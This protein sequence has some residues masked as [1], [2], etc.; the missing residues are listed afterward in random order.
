M[1]EKLGGP[2][3]LLKRLLIGAGD[4]AQGGRKLVTDSYGVYDDTLADAKRLQRIFKRTEGLTPEQLGATKQDLFRGLNE[5]NFDNV[6]S[7][8]D[9]LRSK[10]PTS[11][12]EQLSNR[13]NVQ[14]TPQQAEAIRKEWGSA[15]SWGEHLTPLLLGD[16]PINVWQERIER[17]GLLGKGGLLMSELMPSRTVREGVKSV[18]SNISQGNMQGAGLAARAATVPLAMYGAGVTLGY[19]LPAASAVSEFRDQR[20]Q[21][22]SGARAL[23]GNALTSTSNLVLNPL[24]LLPGMAANGPIERAAARIKQGPQPMP[25]ASPYAA[26]PPATAQTPPIPRAATGDYYGGY[27]Y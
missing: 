15:R 8:Q 20:A 2:S 14:V 6:Q 24:G 23:A 19:G 13:L 12:A 21:G 10:D 4:I 11:I 9:I 17:G 27:G 22:Q 16:Q 25:M 26:P 18:A 5:A 3:P 7:M 1:R